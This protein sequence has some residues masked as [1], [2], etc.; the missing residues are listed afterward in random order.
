MNVYFDLQYNFLCQSLLSLYLYKLEYNLKRNVFGWRNCYGTP[1]KYYVY[2]YCHIRCK[3][4]EF[5]IS[6]SVSLSFTL[7]H[8]YWF[9][10]VMEWKYSPANCCNE[11][12]I[13]H[14]KLTGYCRRLCESGIIYMSLD[15]LSRW[16][17]KLSSSIKKK[18]R[19]TSPQL[20]PSIYVKT[21]FVGNHKLLSREQRSNFGIHCVIGS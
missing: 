7:Y 16:V 21:F 11:I 6:T 14:F 8:H 15:F 17:S 1:T 20:Y 4:C 9:C 13:S 3:F 19:N 2:S 5:V 12:W 18:K 10:M